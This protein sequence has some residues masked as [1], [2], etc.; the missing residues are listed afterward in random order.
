M[1]V[2]LHK[3]LL[4]IYLSG[5]ACQAMAVGDSLDIKVAGQ[6][7][8]PACVPTVAGGAVFDYGSIKAASL[9]L[10][11]YNPLSQKSLGFNVICDAP[12]KIAFKTVDGRS[13]SAI[14]PVGT[15]MQQREI[16]SDTSLPGLGM[17]GAR[18]V[19]AYSLNVSNMSVDSG[20]GV[21]TTALDAIR[22][23]DNGQTWAKVPTDLYARM[24]FDVD[25]SMSTVSLS[26]SLEPLPV[27]VMSAKIW[28]M[29]VINKG[30]EL[31]L[32]KVTDLNGQVTVQIVYL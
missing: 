26:G 30:S 8:P 1:K 29:P 17:D 19:G 5:V 31:D 14:I 24:Y 11:G 13:G 10:D 12:M 22:S 21:L 2:I 25:N 32:T 18:K 20:D 27:K 6:I 15:K 23:M 7:V 9:K 28:A 3:A 16:T 4:A